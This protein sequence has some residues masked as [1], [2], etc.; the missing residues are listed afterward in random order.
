MKKILVPTDF[1]EHASFAAKVAAKIARLTNSRIYFLHVV[2]IPSYDSN[3]GIGEHADVMEGLMVLKQVKKKFTELFAQPFLDGINA[4]EVLT[5][6][7][8]H[9]N[10]AQQ[11][12]K[13]EIDLIV[14]G[15]H[16]AKGWTD[17]F[18]GSNTEKIVRLVNCPV[19]TVKR[20][21]EDF[22]PKNILFTSSF[23]GDDNEVFEN[24][25]SLGKFFNP[26]FQ[27]LKVNTPSGFEPT[28][29]SMEKMRKFAEKYQI[30]HNQLHIYN[31]YNIEE[32]ILSFA[33]ETDVDMIAMGTRGRGGLSLFFSGSVASD[34]VNHS[35]KP[36]FTLK[37]KADN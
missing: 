17:F 1:S 9:E 30:P 21:H 11:V 32:G 16:G 22:N 36:V 20:E 2:D 29:Q 7:G 27:L 23:D 14:M 4:V 25:I 28:W 10:I 31:A 35:R 19:I 15:S 3:S 24:L 5:F 26:T 34:L 6:S 37:I 8:V 33:K 12:E 18:V 13:Y